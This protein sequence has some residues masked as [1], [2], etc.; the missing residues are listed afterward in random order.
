MQESKPRPYGRRYRY[1][2]ASVILARCEELTSYPVLVTRRY[3]SSLKD[4]T[5][6]LYIRLS[7][8]IPSHISCKLIISTK[9]FLAGIYSKWTVCHK[10]QVLLSGNLLMFS[11]NDSCLPFIVAVA[12]LEFSAYDWPIIMLISRFKKLTLRHQGRYYISVT[13]L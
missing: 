9:T 7:N 13:C 1:R 11:R 5:F 2:N 6:Q 8:L 3:T 4:F 12:V 10:T